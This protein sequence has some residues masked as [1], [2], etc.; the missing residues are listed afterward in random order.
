M[1]STYDILPH[2]RGG[3]KVRQ[4]T[5]SK[6]SWKK[7]KGRLTSSTVRQVQVLLDHSLKWSYSGKGRQGQ[8]QKTTQYIEAMQLKVFGIGAIE[9]LD[10][11]PA[12][13]FCCT[14]D[15]SH[16]S[17]LTCL[18]ATWLCQHK[19]W[20]KTWYHFASNKKASSWRTVDIFTWS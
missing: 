5:V 13:V 16:T 10:H 20:N 14:T 12:T 17:Y 15:R 4:P 11:S 3:G 8:F 9:N 1:V 19:A 6:V 2:L 18:S 7:G